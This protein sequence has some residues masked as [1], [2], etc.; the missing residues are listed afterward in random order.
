MY[1]APP[2]LATWLRAWRYWIQEARQP[3]KVC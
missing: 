3:G 2:N 1:C